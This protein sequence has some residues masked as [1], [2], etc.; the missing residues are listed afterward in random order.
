MKDKIKEDLRKGLLEKKGD[1]YD[2]GCVMLYFKIN[3]TDWDNI[4]SLIADEDLYEEEGDQTYGRENDPHVTV[5]YG[6][7][8]DVPDS[9]IEELVKELKPTELTLKKISI[10]ENN[11]KYD[12]IKFDII[13]VSEGRLSDMNAKF[14]KLPHTTDYPDY[15]PHS[16]IAYVKAGS[17]KKYVQTLSTKDAITVEA[18]DFRYSKADG[19]ENKYK[20]N[21][22]TGTN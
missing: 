18:K 10:F 4:Q 16:T 14:V 2:Y 17:G 20:L 9:K 11:D 1:T 12:V 7:H 21:E 6:L 8:A 22:I 5:L 15:H 19:T 3:K 13:G